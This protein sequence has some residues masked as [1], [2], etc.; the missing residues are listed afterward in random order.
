MCAVL[1]EELDHRSPASAAS[2]WSIR[3]VRP[4]PARPVQVREARTSRAAAS[5]DA[6]KIAGR[7]VEYGS[8]VEQ[9]R[10]WVRLGSFLTVP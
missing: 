4:V 8:P 10:S 1:M 9:K 7:I 2:R 6:E 3:A 5:N